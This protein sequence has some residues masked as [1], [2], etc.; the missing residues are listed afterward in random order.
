MEQIS[1]AMGPSEKVTC[2]TY[3]RVKKRQKTL[4]TITGVASNRATRRLMP[5]FIVTI[6]PHILEMKELVRP[7]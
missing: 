4:L 2:T 6:H 1:R 5:L 7:E 3:F